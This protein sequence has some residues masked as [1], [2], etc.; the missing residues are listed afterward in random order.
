MFIYLGQNCLYKI[1]SIYIQNIIISYNE[2]NN[3]L[4]K[5]NEKQIINIQNIQHK[6]IYNL[7]NSNSETIE[8]DQLCSI[9]H[10]SI[11]QNTIMVYKNSNIAGTISRT[12]LDNET[13]TNIYYIN[14][15]NDEKILEDY[16]YYVLKYYE[17][18]LIDL[19]NVNNTI[20]LGRK[21]LE[22]I[23]IPIIDIEKQKLIFE[24]KNFDSEI[25]KLIEINKD[26]NNKNLIY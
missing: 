2:V 19:S 23:K 4:K 13:S 10:N 20:G 5:L 9:S 26:L 25:N 11:K 22:K 6:F 24:C 8:L 15:I 18:S 7:I 14:N 16:L 12:E 3:Y 1:Y 17:K 21:K